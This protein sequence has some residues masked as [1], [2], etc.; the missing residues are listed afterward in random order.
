[1]RLSQSIG[2]KSDNCRCNSLGNREV[3][4]VDDAQVA[5]ATT[6]WYVCCLRV[7]LKDLRAVSV[8]TRFSTSVVCCGDGGVQDVWVGFRDNI[9]C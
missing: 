5:S 9:E 1:M 2:L 6:D 3:S 7:L 4:G 8:E